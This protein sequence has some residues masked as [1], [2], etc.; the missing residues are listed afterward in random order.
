[1]E[2]EFNLSNNM[3]QAH[4]KDESKGYYLLSKDVKEFIKLRDNLDIAL[5]FEDMS[6]EEYL[7]KRNKLAGSKL[8]EGGENGRSK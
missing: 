7:D 4:I 8:V 6:W 2:K 3:I 1:M 5:K